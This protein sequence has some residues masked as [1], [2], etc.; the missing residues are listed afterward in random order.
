MTSLRSV[1][2]TVLSLLL[3]TATAHA[4]LMKKPNAATTTSEPKAIG[5]FGDWIAATYR[6][7][8]QL[9]CFAITRPKSSSPRLARRGGVIL[10]VAHRPSERNIVAMDAGFLFANNATVTMQAGSL[11]LK[12]HT[13]KQ[14]AFAK[15]GLAAVSALKSEDR[16]IVRSRGPRNEKIVDTFSLKGFSAAYRAISQECP[17]A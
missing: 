13:L 16:A 1:L 10:S 7:A 8:G 11:R 17:P 4:A 6:E 5:T 9:I 14:G 12:F 2:T 3:I 15:N